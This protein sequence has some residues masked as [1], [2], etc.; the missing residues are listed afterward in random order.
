MAPPIARWALAG[1]HPAE[2][3]QVADPP[4][5]SGFD[6]KPIACGQLAIQGSDGLSRSG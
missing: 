4:R 6:A 1:A 3:E 2:E 5:L